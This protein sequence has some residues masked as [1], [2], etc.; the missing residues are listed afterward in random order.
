MHA[1]ILCAGRGERLRPLTDQVPKP[2]IE[3]GGRPLVIRHLLCLKACGITS[4]VVNSAWLSAQIVAALGDGQALGMSVHHSIE[5]EG[6]L[7]T[8]G[9]I[10]KALPYLGDEFVVVNGDT[11]IEGD[12]AQ[13]LTPLPSGALARLYLTANPPE[14]PSGDFSLDGSGHIVS[15]GGYTFSGAAR[16]R[17]AAFAG[18]APERLALRPLFERWSAAGTL[19][20]APLQGTWFDIGTPERLERAR[21]FFT[22]GEEP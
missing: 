14:H 16:Y 20:G 8:A 7:E 11:L 3:V 6:G 21:R 17:A 4:V 5:P 19:L 15:G 2:L 22:Q 13:F 10:I 18:L 9:G 12:Y 1:M